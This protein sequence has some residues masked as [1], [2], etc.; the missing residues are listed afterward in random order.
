MAA[1]PGERQI[2]GRDLG[3]LAV[4]TISVGAMIGSGIFVL[5]GLAAAATGPAAPLAYLLA[6]LIVLPAALSKAELS[7]AMP[8]SGGTYLF[9]DRA[10]GPLVGTVA[11]FGVW[12]SLVF[13][14]AFALV[15]MG[16]YLQVLVDLP[17][18]PVA[19]V[20]AAAL[21]A[22]NISG[23]RQSGTLQTVVVL[24]VLVVLAGFA[25]DGLRAVEPAAFTPL[26]PSGFDGLLAATGLVF[27]SY[28]G[29][30]KIASIA[31]EIK[32][33]GRTVPR[34]ILMSIGLMAVLYTVIVAVVVG[35][36]PLAGLAGT[37][38]PISVAA[39]QFL[40]HVG[41]VVI[42][43]TAVLA[44]LSMANAG[45]LTSSRYPFAMSRD[46][47]LP[48]GLEQIH[49][50][51]ATP[52]AA[53]SLTGAVLL[54]LVA[55]V[56]VIDLAKLASAFQ[57]LVFTLI[58]VA[59]LIFRASRMAWYRPVFRSPGAPWVQVAG[60]VGGLVLLTEMGTVSI[61]GAVLIT[62][63]GS[64]LYRAYGRARTVREGVALDVLRRTSDRRFLA[65]TERALQ[66]RTHR[67]VIPVSDGLERHDEAVLVWLA[68][69]VAVSRRG[70]IHLLRG[71]PPAAR[72]EPAEHTVR[73]RGVAVIEAA[74]DGSLDARGVAAYVAGNGIDL[75][76]VALDHERGGHLHVFADDLQWLM[77]HVGCDTVFVRAGTALPHVNT[78]VV[79]GAGGPFD[80]LKVVLAN[81][82]A[83]GAAA[84]I[85][86]VHVLDASASDRMVA[87]VRTYHARLGHL[88][89]V[90]T[91][92]IVERADDQ[93]QQLCRRARDADL[94]VI[95]AT[96]SGQHAA[97]HFTD[98]VDHIATATSV[99]LLVVH[100]HASHRHSYLGRF[101]ERLI[102]GP[103]VAGRGQR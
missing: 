14:A 51:F 70:Q 28:A 34:G 100:A 99:P 76:I 29:V 53:I 9:I 102:Y 30:T 75:V 12:F 83:V 87:A 41:E 91:S 55:F 43:V 2:L 79:I 60:I 35:V 101:L 39:E 72:S 42:A 45:L 40:G 15:G 16:A 78:I 103:Q 90:P 19:V 36:V 82:I 52:A 33:P 38:T 32:D 6:G 66:A 58:N 11:G 18:R 23:T 71:P 37:L 65:L 77:D 85:R 67:V 7:T 89:A 26:L 24:G 84:S 74:L 44:L 94:V 22:L 25:I 17:A 98:L 5:P 47:L 56:P 48:R 59:L 50:R 21:I 49:G 62:A 46:S 20:A 80:E 69:E 64:V 1:G 92:S 61:A 86:F 31:E 4:V 27:V 81:R 13:K 95:G 54:V 93:V 3:L 8:Q 73:H 88:T 57:I 10:M 96:E 63:A 68:V 97:A